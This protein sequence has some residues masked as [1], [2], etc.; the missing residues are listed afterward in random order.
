MRPFASACDDLLWPPLP[1]N[2][3]VLSAVKR[4]FKAYILTLLKGV[5]NCSFAMANGDEALAMF[6]RK[7]YVA[8]HAEDERTFL[9]AMATTAAFSRHVADTT[10]RAHE[11]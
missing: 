1:G 10:P 4:L 3:D 8:K 9:K 6:D 7:R 2:V 5:E 11:F